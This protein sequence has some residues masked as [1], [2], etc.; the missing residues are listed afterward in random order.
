LDALGPTSKMSS[1]DVDKKLVETETIGRVLMIGINRPEKRN[2]VNQATAQELIKAFDTFETS[3]D[4]YVAVLYGK[5]GTFCAGY[6]LGELGTADPSSSFTLEPVTLAGNGPMGPSRKMF[7]KPV[8]AAVSGY[9]VAGGLELAC[10]CDLRVMEESAIMGVFCR[11]FG[12]PLLD[13]GTVRLP[14]LIGLSRAL[15]VILTGRPVTAKEALD[16]GLANRVVPNGTAVGEATKLAQ[17]LCNFPQECMRRDRVSAY[18]SC[19]NAPTLNEAFNFEWNNAKD[20]VSKESVHGA[21]RF[22]EGVGRS[23]SFDITKKSKI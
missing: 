8:I 3:E 14:Q 23:G 1:T 9:A 13:G 20:V 4:L 6:D 5:G 12:V 10:M 7:N 21:K 18:N 11:R 19:F 2:C 17:S 15:D 16:M 22:V